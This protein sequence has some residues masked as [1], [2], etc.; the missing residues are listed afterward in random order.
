VKFVLPQPGQLW[1]ML[2]SRR[3]STPRVKLCLPDAESPPGRGIGL[4][5][6]SST[7]GLPPRY[8]TVGCRPSCPSESSDGSD[9]AGDESP[10]KAVGGRQGYCLTGVDGTPRAGSK[11]VAD[12]FCFDSPAHSPM[13]NSQISS[14]MGRVFND[15]PARAW[16]DGH[17][18][19]R[20]TRGLPLKTSTVGLP[21]RYST[22]GCRPRCP[23]ESSDGS[24]RAGDESPVKA[25]GGRQG[26][27]LTGVDGTPR[28]GSMTAAD[29]FCFD[30][31]AQA[32]MKKSQIDSPMGHVV[33]DFPARA[34]TEGHIPER[35]GRGLPPRYSTSG[36]A[37]GVRSQTESSASGGA[38]NSI[39][40]NTNM[41]F[42][43]LRPSMLNVHHVLHEKTNAL[44][45]YAD[46]D[47]SCSPQKRRPS[48]LNVLHENNAPASFADSDSSCS[49][50]K[51]RP[52]MLHVLHEKTNAPAS[53]ADS[54]SSCSPQ[55]RRSAAWL[56]S[57][58]PDI[59][60]T[61]RVHIGS[62]ENAGSSMKVSSR[63]R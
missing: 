12:D 59:S 9:G 61:K 49:P 44:A 52:S 35:Y 28:A 47:S 19:K 31:P 2:P 40:K 16:T 6:K 37:L 45:S 5:L 29:D 42:S 32:P 60:P 10:V 13:M 43:K 21:P 46:S 39:G 11:T 8:S 57:G 63:Y 41:S 26:Y 3:P 51:R 34:W 38:E 14:P 56:T 36:M 24:E 55:K 33:D 17:I 53:F 4:R 50:Q 1:S 48:M 30:S 62:P 20:Y 25:V 15:F 7:V 22:V 18:P 23:S 54:D 58:S 27:C